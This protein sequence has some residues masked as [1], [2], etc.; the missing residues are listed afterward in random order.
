M[1]TKRLDCMAACTAVVVASLKWRM[2][3]AIYQAAAVWVLACEC[4]STCNLS[5]SVI[6]R[7]DIFI[8]STCY[9]LI[10]TY[11]TRSYQSSSGLCLIWNIPTK[12]HVLTTE[13]FSTL[14]NSP[15]REN[16]V[17]KR[18]VAIQHERPKEFDVRTQEVD[19]LKEMVLQFQE[20][21]RTL[22]VPVVILIL[23]CV[24]T[25]RKGKLWYMVWCR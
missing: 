1:Q 22:E 25:L 24:Y 15:I 17:L 5:H 20:Q 4:C 2:S 13:H 8:L 12:K 6:A 7:L 18:G 9:L 3:L 10:Y 14:H 23:W 11:T 19:S 21:L 16:D